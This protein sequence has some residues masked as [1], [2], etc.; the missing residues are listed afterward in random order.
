MSGLFGTKRCEFSANCTF[1][2]K[3]SSFQLHR[4]FVVHAG[5]D[6]TLAGL[7]FVWF[8]VSFE[9][10]TF[11]V[12]FQFLSW[13]VVKTS[14]RS[15]R[16]EITW[17]DDLT[18]FIDTSISIICFETRYRDVAIYRISSLNEIVDNFCN[19][20]AAVVIFTFVSFPWR[21]TRDG[22]AMHLASIPS[23]CKTRWNFK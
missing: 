9:R 16:F 1:R 2:L 3:H 8:W 15:V 13:K 22:V 7:V 12:T 20:A 19:S 21:K 10:F 11:V 17:H 4:Y 5:Y 23:W 14:K 6:Y 18:N